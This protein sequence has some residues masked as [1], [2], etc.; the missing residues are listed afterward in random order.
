MKNSTKDTQ[1]VSWI[2]KVGSKIPDP[3]LIFI[4]LFVIVLALSA[5]F[6]GY[7]FET[8]NADGT[9]KANTIKN[10]FD[11]ENIRWMF[12]NALTTNWLSYANGIL[13][14]ILIIM[15]GIGIAEESGLFVAL[16][17]KV[18]R[19]IP[20]R[21][22]PYLLVFL[23]IL[24]NIAS[25]A[26]YLVLIPL[27]GLL[28]L[29]L[30]KNPLIGMFA[31]FAGVSAGFSANLIPATVSDIIV[32]SNAQAFA[33]SQNVPFLSYL[34]KELQPATM[35]FYFLFVSTFVLVFIGGFITNHFIAPKYE[36][37]NYSIPEDMNLENFALTSE[38]RKGLRWSLVGFLLSGV[39]VFLLARGPLASY[40]DADLD[41]TV[42]PFVDNIILQSTFMFLVTGAF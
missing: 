11:I 25:D 30:K 22:L 4:G 17:K 21:S 18:G 41:K 39:L 37:I 10:M 2:E 32:G 9:T 26:G 27:A 23:G 34:G 24:S 12:N 19:N 8:L 6:G 33:A 28:Y 15:F 40:Y 20:A 5:I 3:V 1:K 29:G 16:I 14:T 31:A 35:H 7:T 13:G 38:E 36:K 42:K